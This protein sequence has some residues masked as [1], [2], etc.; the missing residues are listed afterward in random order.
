MG[1]RKCPR[2][3]RKCPSSLQTK[4]VIILNEHFLSSNHIKWCKLIDFNLTVKNDTRAGVVVLANAKFISNI[5]G[6]QGSRR[7]IPPY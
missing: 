1:S 2:G 5:E 4:K 6:C 3:P 7:R